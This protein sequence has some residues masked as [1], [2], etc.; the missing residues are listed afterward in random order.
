M[1]AFRRMPNDKLEVPRG[2]AVRFT[3]SAE[4]DG[5]PERPR[6]A[7]LPMSDQPCVGP[8]RKHDPLIGQVW[9]RSTGRRVWVVLLDG[10]ARLVRIG[11]LEVL[12]EADDYLTLL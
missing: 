3:H 6:A 1:P 5:M 10:T 11:D 4:Q 8:E 2:T 9:D 7:W 12:D